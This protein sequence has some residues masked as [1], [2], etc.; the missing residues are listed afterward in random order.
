MLFLVASKI[1][2]I[3]LWSGQDPAVDSSADHELAEKEL[4]IF[5]SG[6][7]CLLAATSGPLRTLGE[8]VMRKS[9]VSCVVG[10]NVTQALQVVS[11]ARRWIFP[12]FG[13]SLFF[14]K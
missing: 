9:Y 11:L 14:I 10:P 3:T 5:T 1:S 4:V 7:S 2:S 13:K 8:V 12:M 6:G